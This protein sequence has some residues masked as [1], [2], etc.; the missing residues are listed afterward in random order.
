MA[1]D[2]YSCCS[3]TGKNNVIVIVGQCSRF[4]GINGTLVSAANYDKS[5][6]CIG[7]VSGCIGKDGLKEN[8][9]YTVRDGQ[10]VEV[11][12]DER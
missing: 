9:V 6:K 10:F 8:V 1:V 12:E 4:K 5:G 7:F 2:D 3:A 11:R